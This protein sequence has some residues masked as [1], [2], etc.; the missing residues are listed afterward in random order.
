M[1]DS[2]FRWVVLAGCWLLYFVFG[3][4]V[5]GL[6]PLVSEIQTDLQI[7]SSAMGTILGAWQFV[8]IFLAIPVG[9][10]LQRF[11]AARLLIV[12]GAV[13]AL[14]GIAR[15]Q[16]DTYVAL[17]LS[18]ALFGLGGP[19][20]SA[21]IPQTVSRWFGEKQRGLAM[22]VYITGPAVAGVV[23]Y[24]STQSILMPWL[25]GDWRRV[26]LVWAFVALGA[27]VVWT[28]I[29]VLASRVEGAGDRS[30]EKSRPSESAWTVVKMLVGQRNVVLLLTI[31]AGV[32]TI[33]HGMRNWLPEIIR[34]AGWDPEAAGHLSVVPVAMGIVGALS[35]PRKATRDRRLLVLQCLFGL[36]AIG[37]ILISLGHIVPLLFG[38]S[39]LGLASGALMT[40][41][42][43]SLIEQKSVGPQNAGLA[44]GMFFSVAEVGSV[45]G[46]VMIGFVY[47]YSGSFQPALW[48]LGGLAVC[49]LIV[50]TFVRQEPST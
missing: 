4:S 9:F 22:G 14:S 26:L 30:T 29:S 39:C 1:S 2:P 13:I 18:V 46:P 11:G 16:S 33:D 8:Y 34:A 12:G 27:A 7:S 31:G 48:L 21:G 42:L 49:L 40:I 20:I 35:F 6:A 3:L 15:A 41:T 37:C 17:L 5:A 28:I 24:S 45:S 25:E 50:V 47:D 43:L 10:A 23:A 32:L 38:L 36:S 19:I 44:G